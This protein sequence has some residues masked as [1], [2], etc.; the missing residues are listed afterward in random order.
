MLL[1][2]CGE[3]DVALGG[4]FFLKDFIRVVVLPPVCRTQQG[5]G[6]SAANFFRA[7]TSLSVLLA[8]FF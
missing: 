6:R 4:A 5:A 8:D 7:G 3:Q 1:R 2:P